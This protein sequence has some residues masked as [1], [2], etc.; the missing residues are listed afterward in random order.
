M[1]LTCKNK[2][3][4]IAPPV[5]DNFFVDISGGGPH[6]CGSGLLACSMLDFVF[7]LGR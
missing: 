7:G 6:I 4:T 3:L 2:P 5:V 1:Y